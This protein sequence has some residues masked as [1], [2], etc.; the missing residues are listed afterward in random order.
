MGR[1][2]TMYKD[3][4]AKA[5]Q[6]KVSRIAKISADVAGWVLDDS[7]IGMTVIAYMPRKNC[8][9]SNRQK[10]FEDALNGVV[11]DDDIQ[12]K[13]YQWFWAVDTK[14]PRLEVLL[15]KLSNKIS[16]PLL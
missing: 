15:W 2:A 11:W 16:L 14:R 5:E 7:D 12:I 8:D 1:I 3:A 13:T 4:K 10:S 6:A 9:L